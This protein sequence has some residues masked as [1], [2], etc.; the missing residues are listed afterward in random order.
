MPPVFSPSVTRALSL[1]RCHLQ[2]GKGAFLLGAGSDSQLFGSIYNWATLVKELFHDYFKGTG[3][4]KKEFYNNRAPELLS[5]LNWTLGDQTLSKHILKKVNYRDKTPSSKINEPKSDYKSIF[6]SLLKMTNLIVTTN[7]STMF[8]DDFRAYLSKQ[9]PPIK[10]NIIDR[11]D[12]PSFSFPRDEIQPQNINLIHLH[13]RC[14]P[15]SKP[16]VDCWQYNELL[17]DEKSYFNF[18]I[19]LFSERCV[20]TV[21]V[22]WYDPPIINIASFVRRSFSYIPVSHINLPFSGKGGVPNSLQ[23]YLSG[24]MR[25]LYGVTNIPLTHKRQGVFWKS[26]REFLSENYELQIPDKFTD[27]SIGTFARLLDSFGDYE[28]AHQ[29]NFLFRYL[30]LDKVEDINAIQEQLVSFAKALTSSTGSSK[31]E[32]QSLA[33]IEKHLRHYLYLYRGREANHEVRNALWLKLYEQMPRGAEWEKIDERLKFDF[34]SGAFETHAG[35]GES[36]LRSIPKLVSD[37]LFSRRLEL[38]SQVWDE[39]AEDKKEQVVGRYKLAEE[40]LRAGWESI[41]AK[42]L[43]DILLFM[44]KQNTKR[45]GNKYNYSKM[46][47]LGMQ[48]EGISRSVDCISRRVKVDTIMAIW[49]DNPREARLKLLSILNNVSTIAGIYPINK[50]SLGLGLMVSYIKTLMSQSD[51]PDVS[52]SDVINLFNEAGLTKKVLRR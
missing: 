12:L 41:C 21:G 44:A 11:E 48:V 14:S 15:A 28:V 8:D 33:K 47:E 37:P 2:N 40:L 43:S 27:K 29:H 32:W 25:A 26:Q 9:D 36:D 7:Y 1:F 46:L 4:G 52:L 39:I 34:L 17:Y 45:G 10:L 22:S 42:V 35:L 5:F 24:A 38:A 16:I 51:N 30:K 49:N 20:I 13:G 31:I 50:Q 6:F 19:K 23:R 18:L 3:P